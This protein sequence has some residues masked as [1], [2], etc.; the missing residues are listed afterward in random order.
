MRKPTTIK[1]LSMILAAAVCV[2]SAPFSANAESVLTENVMYAEET[3]AYADELSAEDEELLTDAGDANGFSDDLGIDVDMDEAGDTV[4]IDEADIAEGDG[5]AESDDVT[6][7]DNA[8][9]DDGITQETDVMPYDEAGSIDKLDSVCIEDDPLDEDT[10]IQI[11][12]LTA[13]SNLTA[14]SVT[15]SVPYDSVGNSMVYLT[16]GDDTNRYYIAKTVQESA[17]ISFNNIP[18]RHKPGV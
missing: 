3:G 10:N 17:S 18:I 14:I 8:V 9:D 12:A 6:E 2:T 13:N 5:N 4:L 11:T 16:A 15:A 1:I 7:G